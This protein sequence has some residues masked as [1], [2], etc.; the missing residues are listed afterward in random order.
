MLPK[1]MGSLVVS[2]PEKNFRDT[3]RV[4]VLSDSGKIIRVKN[5]KWRGRESR[6]AIG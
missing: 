2:P 3:H 4:G 6:Q 1:E 5:S